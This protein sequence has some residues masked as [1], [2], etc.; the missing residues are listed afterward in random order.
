MEA[1]LSAWSDFF[2]ASAGATAALA[3]LVFVAVS[4]NID[5]IVDQPGVPEFALVTVLLLL[6]AVVVSLLGLVPDQDTGSL[7]IQLLVEFLIWAA[8]AGAMIR[9]S[10]AHMKSRVSLISRLLLPALG[11]LPFLVAAVILLGDGEQGMDWVAG[12]I[13]ASTVAAVVNGW[14]LMVE[15]RR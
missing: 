4:I 13:I 11:S 2:V 9:R 6:Q 14:V 12:G 10:L 8:V 1:D 15:I 7:G 3:G 5:S